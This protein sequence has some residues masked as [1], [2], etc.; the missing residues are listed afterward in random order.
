MPGDAAE[1]PGGT[2]TL[3]VCAVPIGNLEDA[4]PRLRRVLGE[5]DV[6]ACE[7]TRT[8]R[9]LLDLLGVDPVPR[10]LA[11]H[12]HNERASAAGIVAL[13]EQGQDVALVSD[14]GTPSVSDPG[15]E[16]VQAAHAAGTRV[17]SVA[18]PSAVAAA[19]GAAGARGDG[20]RFVGFLPRVEGELRT[21]IVRHATDVLVAFESPHRLG[22][23]L[24]LIAQ[25]Q[26]ERAVTVCREL[27]KRH[28]EVARGVAADLADRFA[29]DVKGEVVL[30]LDALAPSRAA[31]LDP[32]AVGLVEAMATAGVRR[33]DATRIVAEHLGGSARELYDATHDAGS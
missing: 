23:T 22:R 9:R 3:F 11:Y 26:P 13:L 4:S 27:T 17:E 14:A 29:E 5:V 33:K 18:G 20:Y 1:E 24:A 8:T 25:E 28:E 12:E 30:V 21:V 19:V 15:A 32:R 16:L 2:G 7:D 6:V 10:L 31:G